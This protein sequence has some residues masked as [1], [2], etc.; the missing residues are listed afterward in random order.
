MKQLFNDLETRTKIEL[1]SILDKLTQRH[2][3]QQQVRRFD[4]NQDVFQN[5]IWACTQ[6]LQTQKNPLFD[7]QEFLE[8]CCHVLPVF[9]FISA[10][11]DFNL[12]N[13]HW[14]SFVV[15]ERV[16]EPTVSKKQTSSFRSKMVL[17]SFW[18]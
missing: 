16:M 2:L 5:G 7:F 6:F 15:K 4:M 12:V 8:R 14:L 1:G 13:S 11:Y 9:G 18:I 3:R 17:H 10:V